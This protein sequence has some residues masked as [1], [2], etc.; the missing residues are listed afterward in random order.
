MTTGEDRTKVIT[1]LE[2]VLSGEPN[3]LHFY[4]IVREYGFKH[5]RYQDGIGRPDN[6]ILDIYRKYI[7]WCKK[8]KET[9]RETEDDLEDPDIRRW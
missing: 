1:E 8:S 5:S 3:H 4:D 6:F 7:N 2:K 9:E